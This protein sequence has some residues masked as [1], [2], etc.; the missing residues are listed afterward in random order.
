MESATRNTEASN[1]L[2]PSMTD[3]TE[4]P[5]RFLQYLVGWSMAGFLIVACGIPTLVFGLGIWLPLQTGIDFVDSA[6]YSI[7]N[8]TSIIW[9]TGLWAVVGG[10]LGSILGCLFFAISCV[11][12]R[13]V[14]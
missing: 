13:K 5:P 11:G 12:A 10:M 2:P 14:P 7:G 6:L 8:W 1:T 3:Y 4:S 9:A